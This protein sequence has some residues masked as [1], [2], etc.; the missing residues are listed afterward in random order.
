MKA[1]IPKGMGGGPQNMQSMLRQAQKMQE[2]IAT[3]QEELDARVYEVSAGGGVVTVKITGKM[4]IKSIDLKPEIVDPDDIET[5]SDILVAGV[6][7]AIKK[8]NE[9]NNEEMAKVTGS[10]NIP[11]MPGMF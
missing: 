2:D 7:E 5:L 4:E 3:L 8:V 1:R 9:T 10:M 6:N 11:G